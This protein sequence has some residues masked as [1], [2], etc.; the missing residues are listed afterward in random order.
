MDINKEMYE[1]LDETQVGYNISREIYFIN[2]KLWDSLENSYGSKFVFEVIGNYK[3]KIYLEKHELKNED[4]KEIETQNQNNMSEEE[5]LPTEK[6]TVYPLMNQG[7]DDP[8][9]YQRMNTM[10]IQIKE[11]T[12]LDKLKEGKL[13]N[14]NNIIDIVNY[15]VQLIK[16]QKDCFNKSKTVLENSIDEYRPQATCEIPDNCV[17]PPVGLVNYGANCYINASLQC[18][19]CIPEI[20]TY[21]LENRYREVKRSNIK[22]SFSICDK[23][24]ELYNDLFSDPPPRKLAPKVMI[25]MCP[26]GQQDAH[27]FLWKR[28]FQKIQNETNA[29]KKKPRKEDLNGKESWEWYK[30]NYRSIFDALFGGLYESQVECKRCGHKSLTYDP[31]LDISLPI[32]NKSLEGC[33]KTYFSD[34]EL[35]KKE[36]YRC[37]KCQKAV[38]A[39]KRLKIFKPPKYLLLHLKRLAGTTKKISII[40]EYPIKLNSAKF[41]A[42]EEY[43]TEY[44][45]IALCVHNGGCR[46]GHYYSLGKRGNKV[47]VFYKI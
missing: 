31:F 39:T 2:K 5:Y 46:S 34:E 47:R 12:L 25:Q 40:I 6:D 21:F 35:D 29:A 44:M 3:Y 38:P 7:N 20:N 23:V 33:L 26:S 8:K 9:T 28:L 43:S 36:S 15:D 30:Q 17:A 42:T 32:S 14:N 41:C 19:F 11:K 37:S 16:K 45:L 4:I 13:E 24:A 22:S 1:K 10:S 27:E 18:L